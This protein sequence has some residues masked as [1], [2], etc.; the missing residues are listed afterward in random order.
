MLIFQFRL[1]I[2]GACGRKGFKQ[3]CDIIRA[4]F[5]EENTV[6]NVKRWIRKKTLSVRACDF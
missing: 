5:W 3:G 1:W 4:V 2:L 6:D